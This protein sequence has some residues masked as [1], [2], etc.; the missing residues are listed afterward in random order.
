M[1][2]DFHNL[3][4]TVTHTNHHNKNGNDFYAIEYICLYPNWDCHE[5]EVKLHYHGRE[6]SFSIFTPHDMEKPD[7]NDILMTIFN[8]DYI[9]TTKPRFIDDNEYI[10]FFKEYGDKYDVKKVLEGLYKS[11]MHKAG[12]LRKLIGTEEYNKLKKYLGY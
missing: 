5:W 12:L 2:N 4:C 1:R 3:K 11:G 10:S 8:K 9:N 7:I 6:K